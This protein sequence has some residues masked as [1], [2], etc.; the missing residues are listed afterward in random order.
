MNNDF[1]PTDKF[2]IFFTP[3]AIKI[4]KQAILQEGQINDGVRVAIVGGG[5]SGYQYAL[6]FE[7]NARE[8]DV[9]MYFD[10]LKVF[11]D[12]ISAEY[13]RGTVIDY[14]CTNEN[15]GFKFNNPN[16][17]SHTCSCCQH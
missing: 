1:Q 6:D 9:I 17:K 10:E 14:V 7:Q 8:E 12:P 15:A 5:C 4:A 16:P 11:L 2:P 13:L 3:D